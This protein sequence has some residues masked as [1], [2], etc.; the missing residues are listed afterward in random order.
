MT[1]AT[2]KSVTTQVY[3]VFIKT[4]AQAVWDAITR[5]EWIEKYGYGGTAE[6]DLRPGGQYRA[7]APEAMKAYGAP[8]VIIVGEVIEADPPRKLVLTWHPV[9]DPQAET[10]APTR[11]TYEIEAQPNGLTRVTVVHD[12]AGAPVSAGWWR[13]R[14]R[15]PAAAGRSC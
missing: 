7:F 3:R 10:E 2:E 14:S 4:T 5:N 12:V 8:D 13:E 11:L 15:T 1:I 6:Y 9:W